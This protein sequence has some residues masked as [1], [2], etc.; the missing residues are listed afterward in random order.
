MAAPGPRGPA[1]CSELLRPK[2]CA[3]G[4]SPEASPRKGSAYAQAAKLEPPRIPKNPGAA[5]WASWMEPW[6]PDLTLAKMLDRSNSNVV[7]L[8]VHS[9]QL[10]LRRLGL[11][12]VDAAFIGTSFPS[13][14]L[15]SQKIPPRITS[16]PVPR[17]FALKNRVISSPCSSHAT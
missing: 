4:G 17:T 10:V 1:R 8:C 15:K 5:S 16:L 11:L 12:I 7:F 9:P 3:R 13:Q 6:V 14:L 2:R